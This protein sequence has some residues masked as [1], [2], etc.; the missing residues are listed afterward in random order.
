M[1]YHSAIFVAR[2]NTVTRLSEA[3]RSIEIPG[4]W[5]AAVI[6]VT[7]IA[8]LV[9][10]AE[11]QI[12]LERNDLADRLLGAIVALGLLIRILTRAPASRIAHIVRDGCDHF[13]LFAAICLSGAL[14]SYPIAA[15]SVGF[16]DPALEQVDQL[17]R[18]NWISWY[19]VV[20]RHPVLQIAESLAYQSIFVT[21]AVILGYFAATHRR[22]EARSFIASFWLA[23]M[24]TLALFPLAPA[25]GPLVYL[26]HGHIPYMPQSGLYQAQLIPLLRHHG[27]HSLGVTSLHGLVCAPSFHATSALLYIMAAWPVR[28]LRWPVLVLNV[29]MLLATPVE[30]THY[31]ADIICGAAVAILA[32]LIIRRGLIPLL[33]TRSAYNVN[34]HLYATRHDGSVGERNAANYPYRYR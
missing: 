5:L 22:A 23:A 14:A 19:E 2:Q 32:N 26:W 31:L 4:P 9:P 18:F 6:G 15:A 3:S 13:G 20:A 27:L 11:M 8:V 30:G 34:Q 25:K 12:S 16:E 21:P 28:P 29:A 24:V 33:S 1:G 17:L 10:M 7:A